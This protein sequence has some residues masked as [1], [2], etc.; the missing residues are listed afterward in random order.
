VHYG[1]PLEHLAL[2]R[3]HRQVEGSHRAAAWRI[4]VRHVSEAARPAVV[5][6]MQQALEAWL[7]YRDDVARACGLGGPAPAPRQVTDTADPT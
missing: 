5:S 4:I 7:S 1:L 3:A 6:A 2:T